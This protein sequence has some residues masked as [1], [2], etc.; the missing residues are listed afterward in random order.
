MLTQGIA[1]WRA[2]NV[3]VINVMIC[4]ATSA[5][6]L[7][8]W[9]NSFR[10]SRA[11]EFCAIKIR[12]CSPRRRPLFQKWKLNAQNCSLDFIQA[13]IAS[14]DMVKIAR[15]H[16]VFSKSSQLS[17]ERLIPADDH[18]CIAGGAEILRRIKTKE[19]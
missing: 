17:R 10:Q 18:P 3:L 7:G 6:G 2:D 11:S 8:S 4:Q 5:V 9:S 12:R 15:L 13:K 14:N 16:S 19:T 1:H